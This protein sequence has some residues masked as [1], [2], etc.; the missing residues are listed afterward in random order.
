VSARNRASTDSIDAVW[1][2]AEQGDL[3]SAAACERALAGI[4]RRR[5]EVVCH[6]GERVDGDPALPSSFGRM[7]VHELWA[8][9]YR[10]LRDGAWLETAA[11]NRWKLVNFET[12]SSDARRT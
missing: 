9:E 8:P 2:I 11:R 3:F 4:G 12:V 5:V 6:P 7:R 10:S 1:G